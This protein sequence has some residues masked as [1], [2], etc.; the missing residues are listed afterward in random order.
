MSAERSGK[1]STEL[2]SKQ[3]EMMCTYMDAQVR[4][5]V[6]EWGWGM[7]G[8]GEEWWRNGWWGNEGWGNGDGVMGKE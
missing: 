4:M 3:D 2:L 8:V 7:E 1:T 6:G 5:G